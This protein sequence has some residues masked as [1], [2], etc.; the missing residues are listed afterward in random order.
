MQITV[1]TTDFIEGRVI[2][3]Y[4]DV[5]KSSI[6]VGTDIALTD[7][8]GGTSQKYRNKLNNSYDKALLELKLKALSVGADAIVGLHTDFEEI[9]GKGKTRFVVSMFGTAVRLDK[10]TKDGPQAKEMDGVVSASSLRRQQLMVTMREKLENDDYAVSEQD[11]VDIKTYSLNDL[12]PLLYKRYLEIAAEMV[13]TMPLAEKKLL[14]ANFIPFLK[15][16]GYDEASKVVYSDIQTAPYCT[17][18]IIK[19]CKLFNPSLIA[20]LLKPENKHF[21][22]SILD[23]D[24]HGYNHA[25]L[26]DMKR[27]EHFLDNLPDTG[28]YIEGREGLFSKTGTLLVCERGHTSAVELGGHCTEQMDRSGAICNLN[29]KGVTEA[30]MAEI[31]QFKKK[32]EILESL[33]ENA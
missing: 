4:I 31:K 5:L 6:V 32:I 33:L 10:P 14:L 11:W 21:I 23:S 9:F 17:S 27:I 25:D 3:E 13:S 12:A 26:S 16:M 19:E 24:K 18:D 30:E 7:L 20:E 15:S 28:H 22:I 2:L 1:T 8:F 29:V